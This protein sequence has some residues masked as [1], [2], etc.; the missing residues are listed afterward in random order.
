MCLFSGLAVLIIVL[1]TW[2][3]RG[4]STSAPE[5]LEQ[6]INLAHEAGLMPKL[7]STWVNSYYEYFFKNF[8]WYTTLQLSSKKCSNF[9]SLKREGNSLNHFYISIK[10]YSI[11]RLEQQFQLM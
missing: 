9:S 7:H 4:G 3:E 10:C 11:L 1:N 8:L 6:F 2:D 5:Y